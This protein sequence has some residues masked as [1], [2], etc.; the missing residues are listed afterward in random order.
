[1]TIDY[2]QT[3][4][5]PKTDFPR[6]GN[7]AQKEPD[8]AARW[9]KMGL[10]QKQR[11]V[12][13]GKEKFILHMGPPFANGNIHIGHVLTTVLK[14]VVCRSYQIL[15]YDAPLVPGFD[16]H[17]LPIEWK[18]EEKYRAAGSN[19]RKE[20][21]DPVAFRKECRDFAQHWVG[22]QSEEFQRLGV[23]G[24]FK[25]PYVTMDKKA[26]AMISA[27]V[28][29]FLLNDSLYRGSKPVMWSVP[30]Q[31]ALAEAEV[32]YK[33][34]TS[35]TIW[36]KFPVK[37]GL[38]E[39]LGA[40]VV[41][42]TTTP[43]TL[44]GNRAVAYGEGFDYKAVEVLSTTEESLVRKGD[45]LIVAEALLPA[46]LK[47]A[48]ITEHQD[49]WSGKGKDF[50]GVV[51]HHPLHGKGYDFDVP[52]LAGDF[53]TTE[54][55]TGFVHIAP[56]HGEDDYR[57]GVKNGVEVPHTVG[58]DGKYFDH[59]P[60]FAGLSVY[61]ADGKK[62][63]A[64]K[65]VTQ[66]ILENGNLVAKAQIQHSYPH[67]WRS[68]APVIFRNTP[69]WFISMEKNG[70]RQ[71]A[72]AEIKKT[73]W[74]PKRG[75]NR[76]GSM[77]ELRGDWCVS[78]QRAWGVPIAI[79]VNKK[80]GEA[81]R[82][83]KVLA[84][85][86]STFEK[87]GSD[88]WFTRPPEDF[89][90]TEY[91]PD[92]FE[93]VKDIIDVWFESGS[94]HG[95]VLEQ[96]P[97]LQWPADLYLEGSDQH[98]G[99]FQSSLLVAC[100]T[101]GSAPFKQVLTHGFI[102]DEKGYKMSKSTGNATSP[103]KLMENY[104]ADILRLWT[105]GSDYTEDIKFGE[106]ILKGHVDIYRR[107]RGTFCYLLGSLDGFDEK[108]RVPL[109]DL[110]DLDRFILHKLHEIDGTVRACMAEFDFLRMI[111][112][113]HN[114]CARE[115]SAFYFDVCKDTLYC[116]ARD[117]VKR[118]AVLTVLDRVFVCLAHWLSPV[119]CFTA[120]EAWLAYKGVTTENLTESI[121]LSHLPLVPAE[122]HDPALDD[123]W[124]KI[125][126]V[127]S[128]V[129]GALEVKR[130]E[131]MIGASLEAAPKVFVTDTA[132][133][134]LL[135]KKDLAHVCITSGITVEAGSGANGFTL[136]DVSGVFVVVEKANG[137]KCERCWKYTEDVGSVSQH[138]TIC[139]RCAGVVQKE[140]TSAAA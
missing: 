99:W 121:H 101:R 115:L 87:E 20:D 47:S 116:D 57:L 113:L 12:S 79:F 33:D 76:I 124:K 7:L 8:M 98:R 19:I 108:Q 34:H 78:R 97:E 32:E 126:T 102:L 67:S 58:G 134:A 69:Q 93:Q 100:G 117:N 3:I 39:F 14:D 132:L 74:F 128:V 2:G 36:V 73:K 31:T 64:N 72:L 92:D 18:I 10:Y 107:I 26:E 37:S 84:R 25:N 140:L 137:S 23:L 16:C 80:T 71:K 21:I 59:V 42:W 4:H 82:D 125:L 29:K 105:V 28:H 133:A 54:A 43:W 53:V 91:K 130:T 127:R 45:R 138:P 109:K 118:R 46:F 13:K 111:T 123:T 122:W 56:G 119:L 70:L 83:E 55:G 38:K 17:G 85:I 60:L 24:D 49:V 5:L 135:Q 81:L 41:A 131:K 52:L 50:A 63:P 35:D 40:S 6:R 120:E 77:V 30:E 136:Q 86:I 27:E 94:T 1:M 88:A 139:A 62:G 9:E 65:L 22:V 90:G 75:E 68:K 44:P 66:A 129:T 89:L 61:M 103:A 96:R 48:G 15:G 11:A 110:S 106:A 104:G 95:F 114:F 51:C 112:V